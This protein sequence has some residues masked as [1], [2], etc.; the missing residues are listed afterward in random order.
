VEGLQRRQEGG[1]IGVEHAGDPFLV[2]TANDTSNRR[3]S[4]GATLPLTPNRV[5]NRRCSTSAPYRNIRV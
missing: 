1:E 4:R 3:P 5:N 2:G